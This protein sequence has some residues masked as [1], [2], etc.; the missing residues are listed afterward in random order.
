[1]NSENCALFEFADK[2]ADWTKS[3]L[4]GFEHLAGLRF[5]DAA[6]RWLAAENILIRTTA[7][8]PVGAASKSNAAAACLL[9]GHYQAAMRFFDA[10]ED[11]WRRTTDALATLDVPMAGASSSFHFHLAATVPGPLIAARR[12]RY[13]QL[14]ETALAIV[15]FNRLFITGHLETSRSLPD[16]ARGLTLLLS[17]AFGPAS[18]EVRLLSASAAV[19]DLSVIGEI[20]AAK[21]ADIAGRP[22]TLLTALSPECEQLE[23][24]TLMTA[25]LAVPIFARPHQSADAASNRISHHETSQNDVR[26]VRL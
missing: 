9:L 17:D 19:N 12:E 4:C 5:S 2:T 16:S 11:E 25:L 26:H 8:D 6:R 22:A 1:M 24:A 21:I 20:Y 15:R 13:V 7:F 23:R 14:A 18:P 10:A 3:T